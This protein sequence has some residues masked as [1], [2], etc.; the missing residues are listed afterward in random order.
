MAVPTLPGHLTVTAVTPGVAVMM[1][2][3]ADRDEE[4]HVPPSRGHL[5]ATGR[6]LQPS[7]RGHAG[8]DKDSDHVTA[9]HASPG[10][11]QPQVVPG[12]AA[13]EEGLVAAHFLPSGTAGD[14]TAP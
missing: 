4:R 11:R 2:A 9:S 8:G 12:E 6:P 14:T 10:A 3:L 1:R 5:S 13:G 7:A